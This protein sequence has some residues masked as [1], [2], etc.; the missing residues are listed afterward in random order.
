MRRMLSLLVIAA[1]PLAAQVEVIEEG[2]VHEAYLTSVHGVVALDSVADKPPARVDEK[3]PAKV[4]KGTQWVPGYWAW[5]EARDDFIWV[6]GV[7]RRSPP[8]HQWTPGEWK[9]QKG[10]WVWYPGFWSGTDL[11][12]I[13][14]RPPA[15]NRERATI[16][17]DDDAFWIP[18]YWAYDRKSD[19]YKWL[20]G[21]WEHLN[22]DWVFVPPH[23]MVRDEGVIFIPGYWDWQFEELGRM[24]KNIAISLAERAGFSY[25][26]S[27]PLPADAVIK[28]AFLRYP[29]YLPWYHH[30]YYYHIGWWA[31]WCCTPPWWASWT[32]WSLSWADQWKLFWWWGHEES[33]QPSWMTSTMAEQ[34]MPSPQ[35]MLSMLEGIRP[36]FAMPKG[37]AQAL[38][39]TGKLEIPG[40]LGRPELLGPGKKPVE[41][42][43]QV[44]APPQPPQP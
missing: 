3:E 22:P 19:S 21:R 17:P 43:A 9:E 41:G 6:V 18:G 36:P 34:I 35:L 8:G 29:D 39:P 44:D 23:Y 42:D 27:E 16:P 4:G 25:T 20:K 12:L 28:R 38:R 10:D 7:W 15:P 13:A 11:E 26:P 33:E 5:S 24:Y 30:H 32:W 37:N 14:K 1:A 40:Q 2:P 31:Q